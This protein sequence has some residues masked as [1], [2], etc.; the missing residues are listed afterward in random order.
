[1]KKNLCVI[2]HLYYTDLIEYFY[3]YLKNI[4]EE[5]DI[6]ITLT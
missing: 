6:Y 3:F 2:L 5:H 1:M 4:R